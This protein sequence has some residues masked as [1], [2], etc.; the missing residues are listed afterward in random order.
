M[1][2]TLPDSLLVS[3]PWDVDIAIDVDVVVVVE[4][5]VEEKSLW[6]NHF[7]MSESLLYLVSEKQKIKNLKKLFN[8]IVSNDPKWRPK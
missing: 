3:P 4:N 5:A 1:N 2:R 8:V 6:S 7:I